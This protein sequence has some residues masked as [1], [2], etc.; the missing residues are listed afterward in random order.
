MKPESIYSL[1]G[2]I[3]LS[4]TTNMLLDMQ[5]G[6]RT[7]ERGGVEVKVSWFKDLYFAFI[8]YWTV[9]GQKQSSDFK[10]TWNDNSFQ[11]IDTPTLKYLP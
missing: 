8:F 9:W 5:G 7:E 6:F 11:T 1:A 2:M 10:L 3:Q 4:N